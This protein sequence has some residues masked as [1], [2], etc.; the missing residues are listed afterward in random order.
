[1]SRRTVLC[2][3]QPLLQTRHP[4]AHH[5]EPPP[6]PKRPKHR[7]SALARVVRTRANLQGPPGGRR[8]G[9][10]PVFGRTGEV[11]ASVEAG[12]VGRRTVGRRFGDWNQKGEGVNLIWDEKTKNESSPL[13]NPSC[14]CEA[15]STIPSV[16]PFF[17][18]IH[19]ARAP[20]LVRH[21]SWCAIGRLRAP[22]EVPWSPTGLVPWAAPIFTPSLRTSWVV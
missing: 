3:L 16:P 11:G 7:G 10:C 18:P 19:R 13:P 20:A 15:G 8:W 4:S 5:G 1:M 17:P 6:L 22:P 2:R 14:L 9:R 12:T 21:G